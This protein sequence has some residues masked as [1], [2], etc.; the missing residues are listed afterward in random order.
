MGSTSARTDSPR[1][2]PLLVFEGREFSVGRRGLP[3]PRLLFE[4]KTE[5]LG[6]LDGDAESEALARRRD[7]TD[8][9]RDAVVDEVPRSFLFSGAELDGRVAARGE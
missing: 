2:R 4:R 6:A 3:T 9:V 7:V 1:L 8:D 5:S